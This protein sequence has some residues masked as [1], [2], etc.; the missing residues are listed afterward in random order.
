MPDERTYIKVHD[1]LPDHPKIV[2]LSLA[3]KWALVTYWCYSSRHLTDGIVPAV[4]AIREGKK[5]VA[6]LEKAGLIESRGD[7]WYCHDYLEHQRSAAEVEELRRKR[8]DA[9][10][11]GGKAKANAVALAKQKLKQTGS[12]A[13]AETDTDTEE[14]EDSSSRKP[15]KRGHRLPDDWQPLAEDVVWARS[16]G[17]DDTTA[18]RETEKFRDYWHAASGQNA[19][20]LNW[21]LAWRNWMR[22]V[23][24]RH[25]AQPKKAATEW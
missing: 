21:S 9:G 5:A 7:N 15:R 13:V 8:R 3:A 16:Q 6:E 25:P 22:T 18:R 2:G 17:L 10:S 4:I 1:G 24:E 20:K 23:L 14:L 12:K 11:K 19:S